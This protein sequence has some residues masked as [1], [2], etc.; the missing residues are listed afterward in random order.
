MNYT[1]V[2]DDAVIII[3]TAYDEEQ[4]FEMLKNIAKNPNMFRCESAI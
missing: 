2:S 4:A 1:Y 3:T